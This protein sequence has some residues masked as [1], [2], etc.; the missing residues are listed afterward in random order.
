M[1]GERRSASV[2]K[3]HGILAVSSRRNGR[4]TVLPGFC[5]VFLEYGGARG[6]R[7]GTGLG[8]GDFGGL[9]VGLKFWV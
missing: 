5:R 3:G 4:E 9:A 7:E 6:R 8:A 2:A 1:I